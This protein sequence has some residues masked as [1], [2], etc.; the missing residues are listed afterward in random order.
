MLLGQTCHPLQCHFQVQDREVLAL[1]AWTG[2]GIVYFV[3]QEEETI[4][5]RIGKGSSDK[6]LRL[7][8]VDSA[9]VEHYYRSTVCIT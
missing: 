3:K 9:N 8:L 2:K 1:L 4:V 5:V 6:Y 7:S